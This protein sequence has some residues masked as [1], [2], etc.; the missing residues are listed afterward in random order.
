MK[1]IDLISELTSITQT[2]INQAEQMK[3]YSPEMANWQP[4]AGRW[5]ALECL[6]HLN[7]YGDFYI[8]EIETRLSEHS[9]DPQQ[10][11]RPGILGNYFANS[12]KPEAK[13][14]DTFKSM[15][16]TRSSVRPDVL[17]EFLKQ[18]EQMID[19]IKRS[20]DYNLQKVK[21]NISISKFLRLRLGDTLRVVIYHNERHML[22]AKRAIDLAQK[23]E[24]AAV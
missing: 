12:V 7:R 1:T 18:Q 8:P 15:N 11:F 6:E 9:P 4:G 19:I 2:N 20:A 24:K 5:S 16:P 3:R 22:Q 17:K 14:M 23:Q 10:N 21:T 13:R